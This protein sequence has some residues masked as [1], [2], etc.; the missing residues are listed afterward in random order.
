LARS[1]CGSTSLKAAVVSESVVTTV[2]YRGVGR[3]RRSDCLLS[4]TAL[5]TDA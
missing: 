4:G 3:R 5:R 2:E 1:S